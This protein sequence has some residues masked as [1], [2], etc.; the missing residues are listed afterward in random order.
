M[1]SL[2]LL[3]AINIA[4][5]DAELLDLIDEIADLL[6]DGTICVATSE[7][8]LITKLELTPSGRAALLPYIAD[9][10]RLMRQILL[11]TA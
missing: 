3:T 10:E 5:A 6:E 9:D 7:G 2:R 11:P 1:I 8:D 4:H